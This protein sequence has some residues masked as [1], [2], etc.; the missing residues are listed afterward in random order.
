MLPGSLGEGV[1]DWNVRGGLQH[2][3]VH[4]RRYFR[5]WMAYQTVKGITT[6]TLIWA[7]LAFWW[8]DQ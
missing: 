5:L 7:P 2:Q 3:K 1:F 8:F 4:C 6:T